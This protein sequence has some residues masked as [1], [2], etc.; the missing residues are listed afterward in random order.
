MDNYLGFIHLTFSLHTQFFK[1]SFQ[2]FAGLLTFFKFFAILSTWLYTVTYRQHRF[3]MKRNSGHKLEKHNKNGSFR[4]WRLIKQML[5]D[6]QVNCAIRKLQNQKLNSRIYNQ[7][8]LRW[9]I[10]IWRD[11]ILIMLMVA[12]KIIFIPKSLYSL[13]WLQSV[14]NS[15]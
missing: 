10:W 12:V 13:A 4:L 9:T 8:T 14:S 15:V 5:C 1:G 7:Q 3:T 2:Q 6:M 11:V